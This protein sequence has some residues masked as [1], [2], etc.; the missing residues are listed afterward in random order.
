VGDRGG[1]GE[2]GSNSNGGGGGNYA[3]ADSKAFFDAPA[4][5]SSSMKTRGDTQEPLLNSSF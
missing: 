3:D 2:G 5:P 4:G 1:G